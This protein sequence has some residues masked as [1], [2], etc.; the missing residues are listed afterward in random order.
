MLEIGSGSGYQTAILSKLA[1]EGKITSLEIDKNVFESAKGRVKNLGLKN[2]GVFLADAKKGFKKNAPYDVIT[3]GA[4]VKEI[5]K[6]WLDQLKDE[7]V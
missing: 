5:P 3:C 6:T 1:F 2:V 7:V 4:V